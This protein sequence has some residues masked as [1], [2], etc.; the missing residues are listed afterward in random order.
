VRPRFA[1]F[2]A[3]VLLALGFTAGSVPGHAQ[4]LDYNCT[5][6]STQAQAEEHLLPGDPY[7]LDADHDGIACQSLPCPCSS[8]PPSPPPPPEEEPVPS[9]RAYI[10]CGRSPH[11]APAHRCRRGSKVGA[12]F[13]SSQ[14]TTYSVCVRF[15]DARRRCA[16]EQSAEA[17][18]LYLNSV[19]TNI[20]GRYEFTWFA[21]GRRIVRYFRLTR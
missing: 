5:D 19:T 1:L 8:T 21:G 4:A 13:Q 10:A 11:A 9:Y 14:A 6:F 20:L 3:L 18:V 7:G 17:S 12:Y 2:C 16:E 15:P